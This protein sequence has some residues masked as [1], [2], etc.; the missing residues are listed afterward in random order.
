MADD[1]PLFQHPGFRNCPIT[2]PSQAHARSLLYQT[3]GAV[4]ENIADTANVDPTSEDSLLGWNR[5]WF[6]L[7][8][9]LR[10]EASNSDATPTLKSNL[11]QRLDW[12]NAGLNYQRMLDDSLNVF[13]LTKQFS[14][15]PTTALPP[16]PE[17]LP[18]PATYETLKDTALLTTYLQSLS[19]APLPKKKETASTHRLRTGLISKAA[20]SINKSKAVSITDAVKVDLLSKYPSSRSLHPSLARPPQAKRSLAS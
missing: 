19:E 12:F 2:V 20:Q 6:L 11:A 3:L 1:I 15:R 8:A 5:Y 4:V 7:R 18:S 10:Q 16:E 9:V 14:G 13:P 17:P